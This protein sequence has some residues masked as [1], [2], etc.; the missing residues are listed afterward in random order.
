MKLKK[1]SAKI[2]SLCG[3]LDTTHMDDVNEIKSLIHEYV[4][5][6]QDQAYALGWNDHGA[7]IR[8]ENEGAATRD[9]K[10][11]RGYVTVDHVANWGAAFESDILATVPQPEGQNA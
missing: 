4:D 6:K 3:R 2:S 11:E 10:G 1:L 7:M 8:A 5:K 9:I